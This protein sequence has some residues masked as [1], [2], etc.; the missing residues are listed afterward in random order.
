MTTTKKARIY[1]GNEENAF[2]IEFTEYKNIEEAKK[3]FPVKL[4]K[5]EKV[6]I[7]YD[8]DECGYQE[9]Y[10]IAEQGNYRAA[11]KPLEEARQEIV[12]MFY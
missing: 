1:Y 7:H 9:I 5:V 6:H 4:G 11:R 10:T 8:E 3:E 12:C 2:E